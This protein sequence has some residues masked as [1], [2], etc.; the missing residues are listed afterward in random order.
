LKFTRLFFVFGVLR[1]MELFAK[2]A[3]PAVEQGAQA[4]FQERWTSILHL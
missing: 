1:A 3:M 4:V 2:E